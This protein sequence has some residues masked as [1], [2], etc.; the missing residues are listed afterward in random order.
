MD[1]PCAYLVGEY[2][3][4]GNPKSKDL[5]VF[6]SLQGNSSTGTEGEGLSNWEGRRTEG[7]CDWTLVRESAGSQSVLGLDGHG[8]DKVFGF[9]AETGSINEV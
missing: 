5:D 3:S 1:M 4:A 7:G 6:P 2:V 8:H 9:H